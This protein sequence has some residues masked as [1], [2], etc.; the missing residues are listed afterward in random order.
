MKYVSARQK[1][2]M[3]DTLHH[4]YHFA[5]GA[6]SVPA[7]RNDRLST[8]SSRTERQARFASSAYSISGLQSN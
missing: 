2:S 8:L 3:R 6:Y 5:S 1:L 7:N 4:H